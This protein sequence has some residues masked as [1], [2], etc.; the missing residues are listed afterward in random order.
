MHKL[1][2]AFVLTMFSLLTAQSSYAN[3]PNYGGY[4]SYPQRQA[5]YSQDL[6]NQAPPDMSGEDSFMMQSSHRMNQMRQ[7][8]RNMMTQDRYMI[9]EGYDPNE[10]YY[11]G[12]ASNIQGTYRTYPNQEQIMQGGYN[13]GG[14]SQGYAGMPQSYPFNENYPNAPR[15]D[16][17]PNAPRNDN[18]QKRQGNASNKM[19][20]YGYQSYPYQPDMQDQY[21]GN[22]THDMPP[23]PGMNRGTANTDTHANWDTTDD[24]TARQSSA[25]TKQSPRWNTRNQ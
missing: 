5:T 10:N 19:A 8:N 16:N 17:Y 4:S 12:S 22:S 6:Y 13:Q 14:Y 15:N 25:N 20:S 9:R 21:I 18:Q 3:Y 24:Q 2:K 11:G 1:T 23:S 7:A